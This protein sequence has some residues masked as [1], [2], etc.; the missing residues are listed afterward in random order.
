[1]IYGKE[2]RGTADYYFNEKKFNIDI[3]SEILKPY[4]ILCDIYLKRDYYLNED[5][6][7]VKA[8]I[9]ILKYGLCLEKRKI[10]SGSRED[11]AA[12]FE[13]KFEGEKNFPDNLKDIWLGKLK[14][15]EEMYVKLYT[16][17]INYVDRLFSESYRL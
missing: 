7:F 16:F 9:D 12:L 10:V 4:R 14:M 11:I 17:S 6:H 13:R 2:I 15:E 1:M 5:Y 3:I 8:F